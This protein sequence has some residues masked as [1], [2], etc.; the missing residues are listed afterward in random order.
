MD[1]ITNTN[2]TDK[3]IPAP[4][5][6]YW[7]VIDRFARSFDGYGCWGSFDKCSEIGNNS[8]QS[9]QEK[10]VLPLSQT[11]LRTCLFFEQRRWRHFEKHPDREAMTY[12]HALVEAIRSKVQEGDID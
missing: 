1:Q 11:E 3:D 6:E 8:R 9:W 5:A 10:K 7:G 4:N 12:I 2:L